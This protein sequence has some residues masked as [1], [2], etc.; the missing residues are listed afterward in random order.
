MIPAGDYSILRNP[1]PGGMMSTPPRGLIYHH[2][3][4][5]SLQTVIQPD[6]LGAD[7]YPVVWK[8]QSM[9]KTGDNIFIGSLPHQEALNLCGV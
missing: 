3:A 1:K 5:P 7:E 9:V 6:F 4:Y 2:F 8:H